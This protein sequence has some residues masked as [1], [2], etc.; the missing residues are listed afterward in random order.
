VKF[1]CYTKTPFDYPVGSKFGFTAT[2]KCSNKP[3]VT[4]D[5]IIEIVL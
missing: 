1:L 5:P 3:P 4:I 2:I